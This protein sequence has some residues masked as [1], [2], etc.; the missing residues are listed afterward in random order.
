MERRCARRGMLSP[1]ERS[2][3]LPGPGA[4]LASGH[5]R[6]ADG[7]SRRC[8]IRGAGPHRL[9]CGRRTSACGHQ[10]LHHAG[11]PGGVL[12]HSPP[13]GAVRDGV[14]RPGLV[15]GCAARGAHPRS[16]RCAGA[17][18]GARP[19]SL[20]YVGVPGAPPRG[21][22]R[23]AS[24]GVARLR[25][26]RCEYEPDV[27]RRRNLRGARGQAGRHHVA[28][29][30]SAAARRHRVPER[31]AGAR[32]SGGPCRRAAPGR[33]PA[34]R[35]TR[36]HGALRRPAQTIAPDARPGRPAAA[37]LPRRVPAVPPPACSC[38]CAASAPRLARRRA[39][40]LSP[41]SLPREVR[42]A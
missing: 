42:Q 39:W 6:R 38:C 21:R 23:C 9:A 40:P 25:P 17:E 14:R 4:G 35:W 32:R 1:A 33:P 19:H 37:G 27:A 10:C 12:R 34:C 16:F 11:A 28:R 22:S 13:R 2:C 41:S 36:R 7:G 8:R 30:A 31:A 20:R 5:G 29:R 3:A 18:A 26:L 24:A 15:G